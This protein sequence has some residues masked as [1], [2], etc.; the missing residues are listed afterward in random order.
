M[1]NA[2]GGVG[3]RFGEPAS[4]DEDALRSPWSA[5]LLIYRKA[6]ILVCSVYMDLDDRFCEAVLADRMDE[7]LAGNHWERE[8]L[9]EANY[10]EYLHLLTKE[11]VVRYAA[12]AAEGL[13]ADP[14][15]RLATE[16]ILGDTG[17][18]GA[19][20]DANV[21]ARVHE[22]FEH[23]ESPDATEEAERILSSTKRRLCEYYG[24]VGYGLVRGLLL[25]AVLTVAECLFR[26][27]TMSV[28]DIR[29]AV[30][31]SQD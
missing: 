1:S 14:D 18:L 23:V 25:P 16:R 31:A 22:L 5:D 24:A 12:T 21:V 2:R 30:I 6:A 19:V 28:E 27:T 4:V 26:G 9:K 17:G 3:A 15:S 11:C 20:D 29:A 10:A 8:H 7:W 13:A